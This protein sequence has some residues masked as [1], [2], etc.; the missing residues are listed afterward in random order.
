MTV[1]PDIAVRPWDEMW[2]DGVDVP[3][4]LPQRRRDAV[5]EAVAHARPVT[6]DEAGALGA[7]R[8]GPGCVALALRG[9][10]DRG[11][12][13]LLHALADELPRQVSCEL[14]RVADL[15]EE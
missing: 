1:D 11:A 7:C 12:R 5:A 9:R 14:V 6:P 3:A 4:D 10:F 8:Y 2:I 13:D 15:V